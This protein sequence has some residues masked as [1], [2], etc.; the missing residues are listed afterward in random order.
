MF[1]ALERN[2]LIAKGLTEEQVAHLERVG[3]QSRQDFLTVGDVNTLVELVGLPAS[4]AATVMTWAT[5]HAGAPAAAVATP[6]TIVVDSPDAQ[7]CVHCKAKQPKDYSAGDL[8]GSC[9]KQ[10]E[11]TRAC[12]WCGSSGPGNFCRNCAARYVPTAELELAVQL[13]RDGIPKDDIPEKLVALDAAGKE[14]L[15]A[16][17]RRR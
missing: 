12:F 15:W 10:A 13:K 1:G 9:G 16:R 17:I 4:L 2:I 11:P 5:G 14:A 6:A 8:C 3:I 7:Y